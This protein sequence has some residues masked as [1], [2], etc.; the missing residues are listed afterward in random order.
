M[1]IN[2]ILKDFI[3]KNKFNIMN[4]LEKVEEAK[5]FGV[6]RLVVAPSYYDEESKTTI[7]EVKEVVDDLNIFLK[8]KGED[9]KLYPANLIRDN[10]DNVKE[11]VN[12]KLGSINGTKYIL[13]DIEESSDLKELIEIVYEFNLRNYTPI[14]VGPE[15]IKEISS[16]YKNIKKLKEEGCLFQLDIAS[17][18]GDY[19]KEILKAAKKLKKKGFYSFIGF[20][21][22]IKKPLI[23]KDLDMIS[24][25]GLA[26][27]LKNQEIKNKDIKKN[28]KVKFFIRF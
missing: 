21:D 10:Y 7:K 23:N 22:H 4:V 2:L 27:F 8:E 11:F 12:G 5:S 18:N 14:I 24:K 15:R 17:I 25:R 28:K 13:L 6:K 3:I 16:N 9:I 19:G 20:K 26:I 1:F